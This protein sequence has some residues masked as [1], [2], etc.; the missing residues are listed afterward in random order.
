MKAL[1][2][3]AGFAGLTAAAELAR[4][5]LNVTLLE[6][7]PQ[8]GGKASE[9]VETGYRFDTGP[10]LFTLPQI[11]QSLFTSQDAVTPVELLP[12]E[13]LTRYFFPLGRV[14]DVY[15][16]SKNQDGD[17]QL[18]RTTASL[19]EGEIQAFL[20]LRDDAKQLFEGAKDTFLYGPAPSVWT[21]MRYGLREGLRAHPGKTVAQLVAHVCEQHGASSDVAQFFLRFATY[22]G[23]NPY[24][25]PAVL[26][27][28]AWVELG[29]G[30][31]HP[32][33]GIT[34]VINSLKDLAKSRGVKVHA[35]QQVNKLVRRGKR[36][37]A[38]QTQ[39][40]SYEADVVV[41][42]L[43]VIRTHQLLGRQSSQTRL[44]P[45]LSGFVLL[46]GLRGTSE[47]L[48][49]HN[50]S[51]SADYPQE[52]ADIEAGRFAQDP[53]IYISI[54]SKQ[55]AGDAPAGCENWFIL[56]NAPAL[57]TLPV[58]AHH[59]EG[60]SP[61]EQMYANHIID[62]LEKRGFEVRS[63]IEVQHIL[64]PRYLAQFASYGSIYGAAPHNLLTTIRPKPRVRGVDNLWLAGGTVHPGGGMPL[65]M[66]SGQQA[67]ASIVKRYKLSVTN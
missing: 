13:P 1:V 43:D 40:S 8:L 50:I 44:T 24:R 66:L 49:H 30:A 62:V 12:L 37:V 7:Q 42:S 56:V 46:L 2:L 54:S 22:F 27:N 18:D 53:T 25:A 14:W 34:A 59:Y 17:D 51:F 4:Y 36:V 64:P 11:Y 47:N 31:F 5:G 39:D 28:I 23:A 35:Q 21:L 57:S 55:Q 32:V 3:G 52:F 16:D 20:A 19:T 9:Y 45:S 26:H 33:G 60:P 10:H 15:F 67:A 48:V 63:R 38:V 61:D 6:Q 65:A 29:H 41:S 58:T